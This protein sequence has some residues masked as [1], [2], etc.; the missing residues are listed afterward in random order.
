MYG[1]LCIWRPTCSTV[2]RHT[3]CND[4]N[5][6]IEDSRTPHASHSSADDEVGGVGGIAAEER[7]KLE[8]DEEGDKRPLGNRSVSR[9]TVLSR[10]D[11]YLRT[12]ERV[13]LV[14]G[15]SPFNILGNGI[16]RLLR[17]LPA[18]GCNVALDQCQ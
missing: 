9:C 16:C 7:A 10:F 2:G 18:N 6:T 8:N 4:S 17:T 15:L 5:T 14:R 3:P 11:Q 13:Y 1:C 12:Q